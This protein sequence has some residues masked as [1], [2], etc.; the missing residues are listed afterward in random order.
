VTILKRKIA[1]SKVCI[2]IQVNTTHKHTM[3]IMIVMRTDIV[4]DIDI[5]VSTFHP[6]SLL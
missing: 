6:K 2:K 1:D 4:T 5:L 3:V